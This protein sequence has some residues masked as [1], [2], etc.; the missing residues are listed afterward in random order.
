MTP[1]VEIKSSVIQNSSFK[2]KPLIFLLLVIPTY[3][4]T[5][6]IKEKMERKQLRWRRSFLKLFD[7]KKKT[8]KEWVWSISQKREAKGHY[9]ALIQNMR[10]KKKYVEFL[11]SLAESQVL[12]KDFFR[13]VRKVEHQDLHNNH[14]FIGFLVFKAI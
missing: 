6:A 9:H 10:M 11:I 7:F 8:W 13:K 14:F 2:I 4:F 12:F 3:Q 1:T 5:S